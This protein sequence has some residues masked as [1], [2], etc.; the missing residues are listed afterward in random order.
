MI[1]NTY[2]INDNQPVPQF[3][4]NFYNDFRLFLINSNK[5]Y[6]DSNDAVC[7]LL[8]QKG[9]LASVSLNTVTVNDWEDDNKGHYLIVCWRNIKEQYEFIKHYKKLNAKQAQQPYASYH[10]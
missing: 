2:P 1:F 8:R 10:H 4:K 9:L 7:E 5:V 3:I 6:E